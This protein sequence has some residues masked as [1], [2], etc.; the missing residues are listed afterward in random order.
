MQI[1]HTEFHPSWITNVEKK[2]TNSLTPLCKKQLALHAFHN[3]YNHL[4]SFYGLLQY[5]ILA[6]YN[7]AKHKQ[8]SIY[9]LNLL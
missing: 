3:T 4:R 8:D 2:D 7:T 9:A 5:Q 1:S 6:K